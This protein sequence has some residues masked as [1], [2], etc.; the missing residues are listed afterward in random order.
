V[1]PVDGRLGVLLTY[2]G[3]G[4]MLRRRGAGAATP[5]YLPEQRMCVCLVCDHAGP[6]V[7]CSRGST[8]TVRFPRIL[9]SSL[10]NC[11]WEL[12]CACVCVCVAVAVAT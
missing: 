12:L 6:P 11:M 2:Y 5:M 10:Y 7:P 8:R 1:P 3:G 4:E 9:R